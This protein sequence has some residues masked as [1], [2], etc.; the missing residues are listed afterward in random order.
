[1]IIHSQDIVNHGIA[2]QPLV[3]VASL[4]TD[5]V[6]VTRGMEFSSY[7]ACVRYVLSNPR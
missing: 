4:R 3:G 5:G 1:M 7:E 6:W 2:G